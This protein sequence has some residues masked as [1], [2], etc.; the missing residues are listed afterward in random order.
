MALI[1]QKSA[2]VSDVR[3]NSAKRDRRV[4][5]TRRQIDA[6]FVELLHRRSYGSIRV[7][8]ITKK[9]GVGRATFYAHY[10][11]K[12]NLLSSQFRRIVAPMLMAQP[13]APCPLDA[14]AFF[15]HVKASPRIYSA[16]MGPEAGRSP[17]ILRECIEQ[18]VRQSLGLRE[19]DPQRGGAGSD[20][21][22]A[23][24]TRFVAS[25]LLAVIECSVE[26]SAG[27]SPQGLQAIFSKLVGGG[28]A[29][30]GMQDA[31]RLPGHRASSNA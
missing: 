6:V 20:I 17:E 2:T 11:S 19:K 15:A 26:N 10:S 7:S 14:T 5:R 3:G 29:L 23:I 27:E 16:L 8:D 1:K 21:R 30:F 31:N 9:A 25:S 4:V 18:R 22:G 13:Q 28:V 12:D 24:I